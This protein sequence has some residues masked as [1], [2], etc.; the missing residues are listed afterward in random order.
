MDC[1]PPG[2][3]IDGI[4]QARMLEW[5]ATPI[6]RKS[7]RPRDRTRVSCIAGR[8]FTVRARTY[9]NWH[10]TRWFFC[11]GMGTV[12]CL[13]RCLAAF[14]SFTRSHSPSPN[15]DHQKCLRTL[16]SVSWKAKLLP[17]GNHWIG[18]AHTSHTHT[19]THMHTH[20]HTRTHTPKN[21]SNTRFTTEW[22][23]NS[24]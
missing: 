5:V 2:S 11:R 12:L 20:T 22:I 24:F 21:T 1:S 7:S 19:H 15:S 6:S 14:L 8:F 18:E 9:V 3:S 4:L 23:L 16:P 13:V 17:N 10:F